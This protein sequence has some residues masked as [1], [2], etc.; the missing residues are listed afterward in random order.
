MSLVFF[1]QSSSSIAFIASLLTQSSHLS[2]GLP[3]LLL[4]CSRNSAALFGSLSSAIHSACP[5]HCSQLLTS[6]SVKL[7]CTPV[8]SLNS[9]ILLLSALVTLPV[10]LCILLART[11]LQ[12]LNRLLPNYVI[13][14]Y[15]KCYGD[16]F[17]VICFEF[18]C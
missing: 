11:S 12:C 7:L 4:S 2:I 9:T 8:Y 5:V 17:E 14:L 18:N 15:S 6:L 13:M 16:A 3:R 1:F 10:Q